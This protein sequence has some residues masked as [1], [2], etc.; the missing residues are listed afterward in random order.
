MML[1]QIRVRVKVLSLPRDR[2]GGTVTCMCC[3]M[4][5]Q[6]Q[7]DV[8]VRDRLHHLRMKRALARNYGFSKEQR[9][10]VLTFCIA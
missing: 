4:Q 8:A 10:C 9:E 3:H 6:K 1:K 2:R 7:V 5:A